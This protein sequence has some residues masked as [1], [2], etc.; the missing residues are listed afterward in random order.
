MMTEEELETALIALA[1]PVVLAVVT[2]R[3]N[4][5]IADAHMLLTDYQ[6]EAARLGATPG[7]SWAM[8]FSAAMLW[9][10]SLIELHGYEHDQCVHLSLQDLALSF[11]AGSDVNG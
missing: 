1:K 6:V 7:R 9:V 11:A 2:A 3:L 8:L 4:D 10:T 5:S